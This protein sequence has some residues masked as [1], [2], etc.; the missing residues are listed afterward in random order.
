MIIM[1][2][3]VMIIIRGI[4]TVVFGDG[5]GVW[6]TFFMEKHGHFDETMM[7]T[8]GGAQFLKFVEF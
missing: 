5:I 4:C 3:Y 1:M 8:L 7:I 2:D 6:L